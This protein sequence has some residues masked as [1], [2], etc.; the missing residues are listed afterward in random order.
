[1]VIEVPHLIWSPVSIIT[2]LV[3]EKGFYIIFHDI[4]ILIDDL[5]NTIVFFIFVKVSLQLYL[6]LV[7]AR[8]YLL[9]L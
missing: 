7:N 4:N 5:L 2:A 1:M 9:L 8:F 3:L 6:L